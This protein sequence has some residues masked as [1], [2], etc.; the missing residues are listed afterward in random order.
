MDSV[1]NW[2]QYTMAPIRLVSFCT[3]SIWN[4]HALDLSRLQFYPL[5][6]ILRLRRWGF[7]RTLWL[8]VTVVE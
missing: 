8:S 4:S 3:S 2:L 1:V 6:D 5:T 7:G